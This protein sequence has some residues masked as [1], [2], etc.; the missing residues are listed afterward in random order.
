MALWP[1]VVQIFFINICTHNSAVYELALKIGLAPSPFFQF[2]Q[3]HLNIALINF[4][5]PTLVRQSV[6]LKEWPTLGQCRSNV[7]CYKSAICEAVFDSNAGDSK[8]KDADGYTE[9]ARRRMDIR[10]WL[11]VQ[12]LSVHLS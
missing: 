7:A 5:F 2:P 1:N 12:E 3:V 9:I 8:I 10:W 4:V 11:P 6:F